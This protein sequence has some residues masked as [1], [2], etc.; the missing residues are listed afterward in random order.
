M[1]QRDKLFIN[2]KWV[3]PQGK[4]VIEVIHSATEAVMGTIPEGSA[5]DAEAAVAAARAAFDDWAATPVAKRAEYIQKI[6]DGLQARSEELAQLI[7]GEVGMPIKLARAIQVGGPVYNWGN[8]AKLL[9]TFEFEEHVGNSL[10]VREPVG[11]VGA[12]TPWNYPLNQIT[13]KVAPALA[14]GCTVVLKPSEVAPLNAFVLAEVIEEAGLPPG[15]FNLVT[16][17]GPVVGEVLASDP[18]VDMVSFTGSTRAGKLVA[19]LASQSVKRVALE[20]GG[21]S[22]SV[23]LDDADLA[24]AVKGTLSA[25]FLNSGQTCSAHT[26]M[27]VPRAKYEEVKALAAQFAAAYVPGDPAQE[28]T[29][30]GPLISAVQRDRV[31]GYIRKGLEEGAELITGGADT[32]EGLSTGFFVKPTVLGNVKTTDTVAREEIFGP[33]LTVICYDDEEEAVRIANDSIYGLGGGVWSG[34]ESRAIRVARRIRT[35]QVN[36]NGGPFNMQAPF[37]GYKQSGHGRENGKYG[38]EEFLEYKAMQLNP[39]K[40]A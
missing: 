14:A 28:T 38:L 12:I 40:S 24:S 2:G 15:V 16:G 18:E 39:A 31:L 34:D 25:C 13:L 5:A 20:L 3:A 9:S 27:L 23:I 10:V 36:I 6:A 21:K 11:V 17:Y 8:F 4:G 37:G 33:V 1:Q 29:R 26:R 35:G 19:E 22:A 30:L 7:A 32:P